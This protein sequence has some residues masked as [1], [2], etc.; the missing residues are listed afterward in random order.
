[1]QLGHIVEGLHRQHEVDVLSVRRDDQGHVERTG[2]T[3]YL[4]VPLPDGDLA[5]QIEVFRRALRRQLEGADYDVVHFRDGWSGVTALEMQGAQDF[6]TVFDL[7]RSPMAEPTLTDLATATELERAEQTCVRR[8]DMVLA[9]TEPSRQ[10]LSGFTNAAKIHV[11]PPGVNIDRFDWEDL[12]ADRVPIVLYLGTLTPGR[13]VRVL[14]RAMLDVAAASN[15]VLV[16]AGPVSDAFKKSLLT[17]VSDL[18]LEGRVRILGEVP[19]VLAP[20]VIAR[21][22]VCVAPGAAEL[23]P[24]PTALFPTKILEYMACR[25]S[26]VAPSRGTVEMLFRDGED[27]LLFKPGAPDDLANKILL[28]LRETKLRNR[29]A[30]AGYDLVRANCTASGTRRSL[31]RAYHW[32]AEQDEFR[33]RLGSPGRANPGLAPITDLGLD[34]NVRKPSHSDTAEEYVDDVLDEDD[35]VLVNSPSVDPGEV[36]RVE[37]MPP[38][39]LDTSDEEIP[40]RAA[41][42][43]GA[44]SRAGTIEQGTGR[45]DVALPVI[46]DTSSI[47]ID[48][49]NPKTVVTAPLDD[50]LVAGVLQ[51]KAP[52]P[53][54]SKPMSEVEFD[55]RATAIGPAEPLATIPPAIRSE[56]TSFSAVRSR[57]QDKTRVLAVADIEEIA[58]TDAIASPASA[59]TGAGDGSMARTRVVLGAV[60]RPPKLPARKEASTSAARPAVS[61][62]VP[63]RPAVE[64]RSAADDSA[65][66]RVTAAPV[67]PPDRRPARSTNSPRD[68]DPK[69]PPPD[70]LL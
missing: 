7:A 33:E 26:V 50:S 56:N 32:L 6:A 62:H 52:R 55:G 58:P 1:M 48:S 43:G 67:A 21:A 23:T 59:E 51:G 8:A 37:A 4:R 22:T 14:L 3:R 60:P 29:I 17:A 18:G 28:L 41:I 27:C 30:K 15:A 45:W 69:S 5:S 66:T 47:D 40:E 63:S 38:Q 24:K 34:L 36:T 9:P 25:R 20:A 16:L 54:L 12:S 70:D 10:Y 65:K 2:G 42:G 64:Q 53:E 57:E 11:V 68:T 19:H 44:P 49:G 13:G 61:N 31:K 35:E 39:E 46:E